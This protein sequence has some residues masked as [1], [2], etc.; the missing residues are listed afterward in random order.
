MFRIRPTILPYLAAAF[1]VL[2]AMRP[3]TA[4][5]PRIH[6]GARGFETTMSMQ[7]YHRGRAASSPVITAPRPTVA[8]ARESA[9]ASVVNVN[10]PNN[11]V[12]PSEPT[13]YV[14][15]KGEDGVVRRFPLARGVK[16][17][18]TP[19]PVVLRPGQSTTIRITPVP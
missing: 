19:G 4:Q 14:T 18:Y 3:A 5:P 9:T 1:L 17:E 16:I 11:P 7:Q 8:P 12:S 10:V 6:P 15:I 2:G 13:R